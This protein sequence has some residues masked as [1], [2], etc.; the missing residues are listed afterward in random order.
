MRLTFRIK[1]LLCLMALAGGMLQLFVWEPWEE[2]RYRRRTIAAVRQVEE[3]LAIE[4]SD[5]NTVPWAGVYRL[6]SDLHNATLT[7][8]PNAGWV[9]ARHHGGG[10]FVHTD[11]NFG[12]CALE[13]GAIQL[14]PWMRTPEVPSALLL[15]F[16]S[17]DWRLRRMRRDQE[18]DDECWSKQME[19]CFD[20]EA[21]SQ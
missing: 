20:D 9:M 2:P 1:H 15:D 7:I 18:G 14:T 4:L 19:E 13:Q 21:I 16:S 3:R 6:E 12:R 8:A 10:C 5:V 17:G 11:Y